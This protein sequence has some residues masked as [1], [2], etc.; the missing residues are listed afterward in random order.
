MLQP[1][2]RTVHGVLHILRQRARHTTHI[3]LIGV[4][5]LGLDED[6]MPV[7]IRKAYHFILDRRTV[8]GACSLDHTGIQRRTIEIFPDNFMGFLIG[9]GQP[10][11]GLI[12]L[13]ALRVC[14]KGKW[15]YSLIA[16]LLFHLGKI[17]GTFVDSGRSS[18]LKPSHLDAVSL[19]GIR[20]IVRC[21]QAVGSRVGAHISIDASGSQVGSCTQYTSFTIVYCAGIGLYPC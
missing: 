10:A 13:H 7:F 19:Q 3:H 18:G 5:S 21:L 14:G 4:Q 9:I 8:S 20:E 11:G 15:H 16:E 1:C 6:L 17:N 12:D 2:H